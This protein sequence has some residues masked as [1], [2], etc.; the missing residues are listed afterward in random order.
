MTFL[1][2]LHAV[3]GR[4]DLT[5]PQAEAAMHAIFEG[6]PT[7]A[8]I[9]A[10]LA[11]LKTKG[12]T[13]DELYGFA[14]ALRQRMTPVAVHTPGRPLLDIVGTGGDGANTFNISTAASFVASACGAIVAK[15]GNRSV[16]SRCGSADVLEGLGIKVDLTPE[17]MARCVEQA[18]IGFLYAPLLHP[19]LKNASAARQELK[20]RTVFNLLGPLANPAGASV[21]LV[22]AASPDIARKMA[23]TLARFSV[24]RALVV[25]GN[26][27]LDELTT[28]TTTQAYRI[29]NGVLFEQELSPEDFGLP[30]AEPED[31]QGGEVGDNVRIVKG[32]LSGEIGGPK[33]EIVLMN[34]SAALVCAGLAKSWREGVELGAS[35]ID[36]GTTLR[37]LESLKRASHAV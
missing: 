26:D 25:H 5:A 27:G 2:C 24:G 31:L 21:Q 9:A 16:S 37:V 13:A 34:A 18:G 7:T 6:I 14:K 10:F 22:G 19:A 32:V 3:A 23:E 33:R 20:M 35:A 8:Q 36:S 4:V 28:T 29:I 12:E 1:E 30:L 11:A 15:H 17:Q